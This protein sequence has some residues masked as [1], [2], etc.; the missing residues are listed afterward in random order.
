MKPKY[1]V[2]RRV[3]RERQDRLKEQEQWC[4]YVKQLYLNK[5]NVLWDK[6]T[7]EEKH[8]ILDPP[9]ILDL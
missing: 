6:L 7:N 8:L 9:I 1:K 3:N 5:I 2:K 4:D